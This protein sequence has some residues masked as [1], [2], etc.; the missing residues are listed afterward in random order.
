M[1][2]PSKLQTKI[3]V[4]LRGFD[5]KLREIAKVSGRTFPEELNK[6]VL[7]LVV[8]AKGSKGLVQLT[9]KATEA[10]IRADLARPVTY[11]LPGGRAFTGPLSRVLG[12]QYCK[13]HGQPLTKVNIRN[14]EQRIIDVRVAHRRAYIAASWL[15]SAQ[16]LAQSV[17]GNTLTR[18]NDGDIP[19]DNSGKASESFNKT[20]AA[21]MGALRTT[22][23]NTAVGAEKIAAKAIPRALANAQRDMG[24]Y[25]ARKWGEA[26]ARA[27]RGIA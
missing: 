22:V 23:F 14:A 25:I 16:R 21:V 11:R 7:Q 12:A 10:R 17:K 20:R 1:A 19:M 6:Q 15:F 13:K 4:N 24:K 9:A 8:G 27:Q 18:L 2:K 5:Q 26:Y 3:D